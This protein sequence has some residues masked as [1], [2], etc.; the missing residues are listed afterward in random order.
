MNGY[1]PSSPHLFRR[2][3]R[4]T[5]LFVAVILV[6]AGFIPAPLGEPAD[7]GTVPNPV[8]SAWFLLWIQEVVSYSKD[9]V[10]IIL[11]A[12][13][14]FLGLPYL[15]GRNP[16]KA[17]WFPPER[18]VVNMAALAAFLS[19]LLLTAVAMFFRGENWEF[20]IGRL[21][22][23]HNALVP[24]A[25]AQHRLPDGPSVGLGKKLI[26]EYGCRRCHVI[27][28][29]GNRLASDLDRSSLRSAPGKI[30]DAVRTPAFHMPD[31]R[32]TEGR[33]AD[34]MNALLADTRGAKPAGKEKEIPDVVHFRPVGRHP[35]NPFTKRC[36]PCHK[37]F[38]GKH[39]GLGGGDAGPNLS[40]LFTAEFPRRPPHGER[41]TPAALKRWLENPWRDAP[42]ALM[43]PVLLK[44][45]EFE[46]IVRILSVSPPRNLRR[47]HGLMRPAD[48]RVHSAY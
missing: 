11:A 12:S 15:A 35:D 21:P 32:F 2:V 5:A 30:A 44:E 24:G 9:L 29:R 45:E 41:W 43:L 1:V 18:R 37:A 23:A 7:P 47:D 38:T 40:A 19:I 28:G 26:D 31:F 13:A 8:K 16:E 14:S 3:V 10:Y 6:L 42:G 27:A 4:A 33:I 34:L 20:R 48:E 22:A 46:G 17:R 25:Y 39:G 36:G